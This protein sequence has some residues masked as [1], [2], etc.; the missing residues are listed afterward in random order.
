MKAKTSREEYYKH[1]IKFKGMLLRNWET[2]QTQ[3]TS[4]QKATDANW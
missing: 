3:A 4:K 2:R 1:N